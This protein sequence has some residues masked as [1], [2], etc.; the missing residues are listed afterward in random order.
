MFEHDSVQLAKATEESLT[1]LSIHSAVGGRHGFVLITTIIYAFFHYIFNHQTAEFSVTVAT[2]LLSSLAVPIIYLFI[3]E[4]LNNRFVAITTSILFSLNPVFL[5]ITTYAKS[6]GPGIF[7][8]ML[9]GYLLVKALKTDKKIYWLLSSSAFAFSLL[10]RSDNILYLV[11]FGMIYFFPS[12]VIAGYNSKF[13]TFDMKRIIVGTIPAA[14][15]LILELRFK[16][17]TISTNYTIPIEFSWQFLKVLLWHLFSLSVILVISLTP[18][19]L[20]FTLISIAYLIYKKNHGMVLFSLIWFLSIFLP[21]GMLKVATPRFYAA[22]FIPIIIL[23]CLFL[24]RIYQTRKFVAIL[25]IVILAVQSFII[26]YPI[27]SFRHD[28]S[29]PKQM[30]LFIEEKTPE[31]SVIVSDDY[32][33]FLDY[34]AKR[35]TI[36]YPLS[37]DKG[38]MLRFYETVYDLVSNGTHVYM[39]SYILRTNVH[40]SSAMLTNFKLTS[41]GKVVIEDYHHSE[42]AIQNETVDIF[43]ITTREDVNKSSLKYPEENIVRIFI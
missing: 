35:K 16:L 41:I 39:P 43:R 21:L 40:C 5:V 10:V 31:S 7:F 6:N 37:H 32:S 2:I 12:R 15:L 24:H 17:F 3:K 20:I 29:G 42:L 26:A 1:E 33:V 28:Y 13:M 30:S 23:I 34:Y 27:I 38:E 8:V 11:L 9:S 22:S 14:T 19:I 18:I 4:L 25:I 36:N